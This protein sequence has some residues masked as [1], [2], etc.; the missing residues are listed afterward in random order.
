V[1]VGE[2]VAAEEGEDEGGLGNIILVKATAA[3][4]RAIFV[5]CI[6]HLFKKTSLF[7]D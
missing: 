6:G 4:V 2:L 1:I 7:L 3:E 5:E